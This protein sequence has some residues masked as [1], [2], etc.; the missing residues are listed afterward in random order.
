MSRG[1]DR[2]RSVSSVLDLVPRKSV[3]IGLRCG[4]VGG[5]PHIDLS[6]VVSGFIEAS[7]IVRSLIASLVYLVS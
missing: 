5:G 4:G 3:R 2:D 6:G 7:A 1:G